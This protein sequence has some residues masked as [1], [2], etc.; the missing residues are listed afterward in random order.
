MKTTIHSHVN[1]TLKPSE[2]LVSLAVHFVT[3]LALSTISQFHLTSCN[4]K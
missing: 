1:M 3:T 4:A 2:I